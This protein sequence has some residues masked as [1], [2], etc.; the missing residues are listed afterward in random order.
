[1][2]GV[3]GSTKGHLGYTSVYVLARQRVN[4]THGINNPVPSV[5]RLVRGVGLATGTA[6]G[7][8]AESG[9]HA[10]GKGATPIL[11]LAV[12]IGALILGGVALLHMPPGDLRLSQSQQLAVQGL[13]LGCLGAAAGD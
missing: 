6:R 8:F 12:Q 13:E 3:A 10:L 7:G 9:R 11:G 5:R 2:L 4:A 1:M